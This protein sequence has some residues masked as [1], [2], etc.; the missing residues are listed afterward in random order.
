MLLK[1][2]ELVYP[3]PS[4]PLALT[5]DASKEG[6]GAV[7]EQFSD[8]Q[9]RPLG[10]WSRHLKP[11]MQKWSTFR[12][13]LYSIQQAIRHFIAE[14]NGRHFTMW[15]DHKPLLGAFSSSTSQQHD[16]IAMNHLQ[17]ISQHSNDIRY[18]A[19]KSNCIADF[20]SR[21]PEERLGDAYKITPAEIE[22]EDEHCSSICRGS[23]RSV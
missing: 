21:V 4:A 3:D 9:W 11:S 1:A 7:L 8:G 23:H 18:I 14:I 10:F 20:L 22:S 5:S 19:G 17:E 15:T 12:R 16:V 6:V 13:E 2:C